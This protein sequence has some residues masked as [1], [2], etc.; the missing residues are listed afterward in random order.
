MR[1]ET[2]A[3]D[4]SILAEKRK[5][6]KN[7]FNRP[8]STLSFDAAAQVCFFRNCIRA[9]TPRGK[10]RISTSQQLL[11]VVEAISLDGGNFQFV[12]LDDFLQSAI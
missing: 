6:Y 10:K 8:Q 2:E 5:N 1:E 4:M 11:L 9:S 3:A 7:W 12:L